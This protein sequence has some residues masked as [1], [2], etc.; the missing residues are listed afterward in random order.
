MLESLESKKSAGYAFVEFKNHQI[1]LG[2]LE[3]IAEEPSKLMKEPFI[4]EFAIQ[5]SRKLQK[6]QNRSNSKP[7]T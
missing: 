1:A 2:F 4:C 3:W 6:L 5:D 7:K